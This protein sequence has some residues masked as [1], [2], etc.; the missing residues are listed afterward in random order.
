MSLGQSLGPQSW[1]RHMVWANCPRLTKLPVFT[2]TMPMH[3][4]LYQPEIAANVGASI[5]NCACFG[6][7]LQII[8][9]CGFPWKEKAI[10]RVALDYGAQVTPQRHSSWDAF[11]AAPIRH[12]GRLILL[13]T[14][15]S[16]PLSSIEIKPGDIFVLG[17][18]SA[19]VPAQIAAACDLQATIPLAASARSLNVA[20][21]GAIA[22]AEARR[23]VGY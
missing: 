17:Q 4:A 19:G 7:S 1:T 12:H 14:K 16:L 18:E 23:Q 5:R 21:T 6:A 9:P 11:L 3:L 15:A 10:N 20:I 2:Q 13:S 22:L 8:E